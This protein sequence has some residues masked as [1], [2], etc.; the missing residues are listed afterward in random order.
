MPIRLSQNNIAGMISKFEQA[1][2]AIKM[3]KR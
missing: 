2:Y 3:M 1:K